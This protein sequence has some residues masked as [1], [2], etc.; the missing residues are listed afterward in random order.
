M[1]RRKTPPFVRIEETEID[2]VPGEWIYPKNRDGSDIENENMILYFHGGGYIHGSPLTHRTLTCRLAKYAE[3]KL[4]SLDYRLAPVHPFPAALSD[5]ITV[6]KRLLKNSVKPQNIILCGDSAGGNLVLSTLL[7]IR[8]DKLPAPAGAVCISPWG[9]LTLSGESMEKNK[10]IESVLPLKKMSGVAEAVLNGHDPL[11]PLISPV[12]ADFTG[13]GPFLVTVGSKEIL[14]DDAVRIVEGA[15]NAG[16]DVTLQVI[17]K[18]PHV[19][20]ALA[21]FVE[22]ANNSVKEISVYMHNTFVRAAK[23]TAQGTGKRSKLVS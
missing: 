11:D 6:Y 1:R 12:F 13:L 15:K 16:V 18:A 21:P 10:K 22:E 23:G 17:E 7:K 14:Y 5:A 9:D 2:G 4:L 8:D 3:C 19:F 20:Q